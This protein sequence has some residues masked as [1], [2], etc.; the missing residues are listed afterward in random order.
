[1]RRPAVI[2]VYQDDAGQWRWRLRLGNHRNFAASGESFASRR[3]A[4][5]AANR[6]S[7]LLDTRTEVETNAPD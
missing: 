6:L 5:R 1:V 7:D 4:Q 3:S 2:T